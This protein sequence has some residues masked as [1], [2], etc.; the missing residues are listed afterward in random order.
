MK[1]PGQIVAGAAAACAF[2]LAVAAPAAA[3]PG[4]LTEHLGALPNGTAVPAGPWTNLSVGTTAGGSFGVAVPNGVGAGWTQTATLAPPSGLTF[5]AV[6]ADRSFNAPVMAAVYQAGFTTSFESVGWPYHWVGCVGHEWDH[7]YIGHSGDG[8][9]TATSPGT[10]ALR[11]ECNT[12]GGSDPA[13]R[14][15]SGASW[16]ARRMVVSLDDATA[17]VADATPGTP[18][19]AGGWLTGATQ[20]LGITA[21][22]VGSGVYRA[23]WREGSSTTYTRMDPASSTCRDAISSGSDYEFT[24]SATSLVPCRTT[25]QAYAPA[26]DLAAMGDGV[27]TVTFGV[28]DASGRE[29]LV[30]SNRTVRVNAP[31]GALP[32]PGTPCTNGSHDAS[33][34]CVLRPPSSSAA[35]VLAGTPAVGG[36]LT[37]DTGSWT[38]AAGASFSYGWEL[39]DA[40]GS[41]CSAIAGE[42]G[43]SL[44]VTSSMAD[45]TVRSVV[46]ATT[47]GGLIAARSAAS[48]AIADGG[49]SGGAGGAGGVHDVVAPPPSS[50]GGGG[51]TRRATPALPVPPIVVTV[52]RPNG[53]G[54]QSTARVTAERRG[55]SVV[56]RLTTDRGEPI[57]DAQIDVIVQ[58]AQ[59]GAHG[60]IAG[61]AT[62]D[63]DGRFTFRTAGDGSRI[64]T[65]GYREH[66]SDDHYVHWASVTVTDA[67]TTP[68]L[69]VDR[70]RVR[71]GQRVVF[72]GTATDAIELQVL[73]RGRWTTIATPR[74]RN[75][76]FSQ[77]YRFTLT[78]H[79]QT[80]RF[81]ALT[82]SGPSTTASVRV[83]AQETR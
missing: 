73:A 53:R 44:H 80:Y 37:T 61:A 60:Q 62:T 63:D 18:L 41:G 55:E 74:L 66:L 81:R 8:V 46:T 51:P 69:T 45:R 82:P 57:A 39:C 23:F 59:R 4:R 38:D 9:A 6:T 16:V 12:F 52:A 65:F 11:A 7:C 17:P 40:G 34:T 36:S 31:G 42:H 20:S 19:L 33:G 67:T 76:A 75:G 3:A 28:E 54:A 24:V 22:D 83:T 21:S 70:T 30:A 27:H 50:A 5:A 32:D 78:R 35:P 10:L 48:Y 43:A 2:A 25:A 72:R 14:C 1:R 77:G 56:G 58:A 47:G 68:T 13:P 29:T 15:T 49:G 26:F 71:N 64:F 79:T